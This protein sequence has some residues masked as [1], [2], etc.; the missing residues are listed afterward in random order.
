MASYRNMREVS[1]LTIWI[2]LMVD[3]CGRG[4]ELAWNEVSDMSQLWN[5]L[6]TQHRNAKADEQITYP[7]CSELQSNENDKSTAEQERYMILTSEKSYDSQVGPLLQK[8]ILCAGSRS[9]QYYQSNIAWGR[10]LCD[11]FDLEKSPS[12]K[13]PTLLRLM[14]TDMDSV[15]WFYS[16]THLKCPQPIWKGTYCVLCWSSSWTMHWDGRPE[17]WCLLRILASQALKAGYGNGATRGFQNTPWIPDLKTSWWVAPKGS[18][19]FHLPSSGP[20]AHRESK[21]RKQD[22]AR[23]LWPNTFQAVLRLS[24]PE[25]T[26]TWHYWIT[27]R[28]SIL[29]GL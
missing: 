24:I 6:Y 29:T 3:T 2:N 22:M 14:H 11:E 21:C 16:G 1:N 8:P 15:T 27:K 17:I 20:P 10:I 9:T 28:W 18:S 12:A 7:H 5:T 4:G 13:V 25:L 23:S 26:L 19:C